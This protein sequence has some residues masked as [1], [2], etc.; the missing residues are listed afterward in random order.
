MNLTISILGNHESSSPIYQITK[1]R[2]TAMTSIQFCFYS[3]NL[4]SVLVFFHRSNHPKHSQQKLHGPLGTCLEE[5]GTVTGGGS[6]DNWDTLGSNGIEWVRRTTS[7]ARRFVQRP[8]PTCNDKM[9][10]RLVNGA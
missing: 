8:N 9:M 6:S 7:R 4:W 3:R 2:H 1:Q 10:S 5:W